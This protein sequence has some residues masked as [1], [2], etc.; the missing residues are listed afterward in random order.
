MLIDS[1]PWKTFLT[2]AYR[3]LNEAIKSKPP[4]SVVMALQ[5]RIDII[6]LILGKLIQLEQ[7]GGNT[8]PVEYGDL[9][10]KMASVEELQTRT[11]RTQLGTAVLK[12]AD[13]VKRS[14]EKGAYVDPTKVKYASFY[15]VVKTLL[16]SGDLEKGFFV[17]KDGDKFGLGYSNKI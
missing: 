17:S 14:K 2:E 10:E 5:T 15:R 13:A 9:I 6:G 8:M 12:L 7:Q 1:E 16:K 4:K 11:R 3:R